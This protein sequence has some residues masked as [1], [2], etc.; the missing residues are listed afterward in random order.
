MLPL[1]LELAS[2]AQHDTALA[3]AHCLLKA[4]HLHPGDAA[5]VL[6]EPESVACLVSLL[7]PA[8]SGST[9]AA[10]A[11]SAFAEEP[12]QMAAPA[13]NADTAPLLLLVLAQLAAARPE[14]L[15]EYGA[16]LRP[17]VAACLDAVGDPGLRRRWAPLLAQAD[18]AA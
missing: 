4:A 15:R 11:A 7:D 2:S 13:F 8:A 3:A 9:A 10:A 5:A 1:L 18:A 12:Q 17:A 6:A 16:S 14:L